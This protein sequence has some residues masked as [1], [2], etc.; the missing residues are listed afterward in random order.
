MARRSTKLA[1]WM[2]ALFAWALGS[3]KPP[4]PQIMLRIETDI[5]QGLGQVLEAVS[6]E[7]INP[8]TGTRFHQSQVVIGERRLP[9]D[10]AISWNGRYPILDVRVTAQQRDALDRDDGFRDLFT[11]RAVA[12]FPRE[13]AVV[14]WVYLANR[15]LLAQNRNC[16]QGFTCGRA[17]CEP[18]TRGELRSVREDAGPPEV[19]VVST[20]DAAAMD[21]S[22]DAPSEAG[23]CAAGLILCGGSCV[24]P[25]SNP[26][27]CGGCGRGCT[28]LAGVATASCTAS[29]CR[30]DQCEQGLGNCDG[31]A[32]NGCETSLNGVM[33]CGAC[34]ARCSG[35]TPICNAAGRTAMC[36]SGCNTAGGETRCGMTCVDVQTSLQHCGRCDNMCPDRPNF[37]RACTGGMC[38]GTCSTGFRDCDMVESNG[39]EVDTTSSV[40]HCGGCG[41]ACPSR[42]NTA[43]SCSGSAC[44]YACL[45]GFADCDGNAANGC[46]TNTQ[47]NTNNCGMCGRRC[48]AQAN[49]SATCMGGVCAFPCLPGFLNCDGA[50]ANGCEAST[51]APTSCGSC[52][53]VCSGAT[54]NCTAG[55]CTG[56]CAAPATEC[57]MGMCVDTMTSTEH[58]GACG[59]TCPTVAN[60]TPMCSASRCSFTCSTGFGDCNAAPADGCETDTTSDALHCGRCANACPPRANATEFC[61]GGGCSFSCNSGFENC[62]ANSADGCEADLTTSNTNCGMCG[63][64]CAGAVANG[65]SS[66]VS[67]TCEL[68]CD[69]GWED[70]DMN[71][72]NGCE[73][74]MC[75]DRGLM[76]SS[77]LADPCRLY[78]VQ[79]TAPN[80]G[81]CR[82]TGMNFTDG[83]FCLVPG[84]GADGTC[85]AGVCV[86][87][88]T[89][90]G[91]DG[92]CPD[93]G[94][95]CQPLNQCMFGVFMCAGG[96][97]VCVETTAKPPLATCTLGDGGMGL[98]NGA[99]VCNDPTDAGLD[100]MRMDSGRMLFGD[101]GMLSMDGG[102]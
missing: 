83:V 81:S 24:D 17:G 16:P 68:V 41:M 59:N 79:C 58:C 30:I 27:H 87:S 22:I 99:G 21:A 7:L 5:P 52:A 76:C 46:E 98:C 77:P 48:L 11:V 25:T 9:G 93:A 53:N 96:A 88:S 42:P 56:T 49:Q 19:S 60:A 84:S 57:G 6:I 69:S 12:T 1:L 20:L 45:A 86:P 29:Q 34:G 85:S 36:S 37:T 94:L 47:S 78:T 75:P 91:A 2:V 73:T 31:E 101:G 64:R 15:C 102:S 71:A 44:T 97:A 92:G 51:S 35:A 32:A 13:D 80:V 74:L 55:V 67:G 40:A 50:A 33:N 89:D 18:E 23:P 8:Q 65:S 39:C 70:L 26:S 90:A 3:C 63:I 61:S 95:M 100:S 14:L 38:G 72:S 10:F 66:C 82:P 43:V 28:G 62:N 4:P 54:P